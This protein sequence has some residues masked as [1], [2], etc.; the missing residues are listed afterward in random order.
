MESV[1]GTSNVFN[2]S[3]VRTSP[4]WQVFTIS[5]SSKKVETIDF[6]DVCGNVSQN[7]STEFEPV[8]INYDSADSYAIELTAFSSNGNHDTTQK[9]VVV[10][11]ATSPAISFTTVN[12]CIANENT[13]NASSSDDASITQWNW[14]FGDGIG[15]AAG[16]NKR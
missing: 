8:G 9:T 6:A 13:F 2:I 11:N 5:Y 15:I 3:L 16:Q 1:T 14:E 10:K 12:A 7:S 4:T